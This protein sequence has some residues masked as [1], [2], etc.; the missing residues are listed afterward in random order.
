MILLQWIV[1][2]R[3]YAYP[4]WVRGLFWLLPP[5]L[6]AYRILLFLL[7]DLNFFAIIKPVSF[8]TSA[9]MRMRVFITA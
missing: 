8:K 3:D 4:S 7:L 2:R 9:M 6:W 1:P 5:L